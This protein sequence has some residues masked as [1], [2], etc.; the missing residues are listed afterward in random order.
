MGDSSAING[1]LQNAGYSFMPD[2][3][4]KQHSLYLPDAGYHR[5]EKIFGNG[6]HITICLNNYHA[7]RFQSGNPGVSFPDSL[8]EG[9]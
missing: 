5:M 9:K 6:I 4:V 3:I 2:D 8:V 7:V 1:A